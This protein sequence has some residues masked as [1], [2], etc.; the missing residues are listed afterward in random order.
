M[1]DGIWKRGCKYTVFEEGFS[2]CSGCRPGGGIH[3]LCTCVGCKPWL[4][5]EE[6]IWKTQ[7]AGS[8]ALPPRRC[9]CPGIGGQRCR[10][11][12]AE[13]DEM[14]EACRDSDPSRPCCC[15]CDGCRPRPPPGPPPGRGE[16]PLPVEGQPPR[17]SSAS[18]WLAGGASGSS[19]GGQHDAAE[20]GGGAAPSDQPGTVV[21]PREVG[22]LG[23][24]NSTWYTAEEALQLQLT[25]R[26]TLLS[27]GLGGDHVLFPQLPLYTVGEGLEETVGESHG[28]GSADNSAGAVVPKATDEEIMAFAAARTVRVLV[29]KGRFA[30]KSLDETVLLHHCVDDDAESD[31]TSYVFEDR[32]SSD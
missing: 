22:N 6:G 5:E 24:A 19:P 23:G 12:A 14:C 13:G 29:P 30:R 31:H 3:C 11:A 4:P 25:T 8:A 26:R 27:R 20:A 16:P 28:T 2:R 21:V 9:S 7:A 15:F 32:S 17:P 18:A 1:C 10:D